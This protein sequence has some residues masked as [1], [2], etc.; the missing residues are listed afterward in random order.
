MRFKKSYHLI[1]FFVNVF[2]IFF[3]LPALSLDKEIILNKIEI[4]SSKEKNDLTDFLKFC[5]HTSAFGYTIFGEKPMSLDAINFEPSLTD[6]YLEEV[7]RKLALWCY[8]KKDG[9][10][11]WKKHFQDDSLS[12]F[13]FISYPYLKHPEVIH[14][15]IINHKLFLNVVENNLTE[16]Q[17]VLNKKINPNEILEGYVKCEKEIFEPIKN[18]DGLLGILLGYG[19][20]NAWKFMRGEE[21]SPSIDP[22]VKN[23]DISRVKP[24]LFM[25]VKGSKETEQIMRSFDKQREKLNEVYRKDN[26][27]EIVLLKLFCPD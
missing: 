3:L 16:F 19:K 15:A 24:P 20:E 12:G 5:F 11:V 1:I 25:V 8:K 2:N 14:I 4:L 21:L 18:H 7:Y 9:W 17:K 6:D 13:S 22:D 27:L 23:W 10:N 26:F